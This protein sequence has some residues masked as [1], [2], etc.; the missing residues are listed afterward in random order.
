MFKARELVRHL[1]TFSAVQLLWT[2]QLPVF[3]GAP[4]L[5]RTLLISPSSSRFLELSS[6][7]LT[8]TVALISC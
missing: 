3:S 1:Q 6:N 4:F 5:Y 2:L 8:D 7:M